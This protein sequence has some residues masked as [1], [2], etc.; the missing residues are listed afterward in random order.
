ML[1][2]QY[3]SSEDHPGGLG[4]VW[5]TVEESIGDTWECWVG[6]P[7]EAIAVAGNGP[8]Q[9]AERCVDQHLVLEPLDPPLVVHV[10]KRPG[11]LVMDVEVWLAVVEL[12]A[13]ACGA[14]YLVG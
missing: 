2:L 1:K 6:E 11:A 7:S 10:R 4:T 13:P 12:P 14:S 9:T 3:L 8:Q 5:G